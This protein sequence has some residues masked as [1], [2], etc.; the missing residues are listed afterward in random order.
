LFVLPTAESP[1]FSQVRVPNLNLWFSFP[2]WISEC[3]FV[4]GKLK[5]FFF[6]CCLE[7]LLFFSFLVF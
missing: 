6:L 3:V 5:S 7:I 2:F 1:S 4:L